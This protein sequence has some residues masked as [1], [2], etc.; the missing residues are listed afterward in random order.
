LF[1]PADRIEIADFRGSSPVHKTQTNFLR[2]LLCQLNGGEAP[3]IR[4]TIESGHS[5]HVGLGSGT[6]LALGAVEGWARMRGREMTPLEI[7]RASGR[8]ATSGIGVTTYFQGG[9]VFEVGSKQDGRQ[10]Q[11]SDRA[12]GSFDRPL[13]ML[14]QG[15]PAWQIGLFQPKDC[16]CVSPEVEDEVFRGALP[17]SKEQVSE[18]L[19][20]GVLG[21]VPAIL[22]ADL[23]CFCA[24]LR[25]LQKTAWKA[26]ERSLHDSWLPVA[27]S[28]LYRTGALCCALSSFG[29]SLLVVAEDEGSLGELREAAAPVGRLTQ[30]SVQNVGRA[31][32]PCLS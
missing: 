15:M 19:Y 21:L 20:E 5:P 10:I 32:G 11:S 22:E 13:A 1:E 8:G 18:M 30:I 29:P 3:G 31:I 7:C 17:L 4:M 9:F 26:A 6:A 2:E 27:E 24:S 25:R 23:D 28:I 14:A 16:Y 12:N